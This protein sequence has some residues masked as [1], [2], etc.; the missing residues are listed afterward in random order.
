MILFLAY[1]VI[2]VL[3]LVVLFFLIRTVIVVFSMGTEV[4]Y[5][6]SNRLYKKAIEHLEIS[7]GDKVLDIGSGDGR[8]LIY[9]SKKYPNTKFVGVEKNFF[10]VLYSNFLKFTLGRSN[11]S[12]YNINAHDFDISRFNKIYL[13]LLPEFIDKI[14]LKNI[15]NIKLGTIILS[16]HYPFG[17]EFNSIN[18]PIKY[19]VKYGNRE[20]NIYKYIKK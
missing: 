1:T 10:L 2:T 19:P 7:E 12:F 9:V 13:Y 6:P 20:D 11:L 16:F 14:I 8:V 5:L 3:F 15:E 4:P 18:N 17:K